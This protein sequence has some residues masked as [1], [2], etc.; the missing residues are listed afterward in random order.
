MILRAVAVLVLAAAL[1]FPDPGGAAVV[2]EGAPLWLRK[3]MERSA[4]T[5]WA[6]IRQDGSSSARDGLRLLSLV[7]ERVFAGYSVVDSF[8]RGEDAVLRLRPVERTASWRVEIFQPQLASPVGGWFREDVSGL[9]EKIRTHLGDLPVDALSWADTPLKELIDTLCSPR[10]PGWSA[11]LLVRLEQE[12]PILRVSFI[13]RPPFVLAVVPRVSS[14]TLPVMLRSDLNENIL[15]TLSPVVGLPIE[16][17][18]A[19]SEKVEEMAAES[20][21]QTNIVG[22]TRSVVDVS[23]KPAQIATADAFVDS[24]KYSVRAWVAAYAGSDTKYPEIGLHAG[25][26]FLPVS[27]W[28]MELYGE[29]ILTANDFTLESRWG[30]RWSP[31]KNVLAGVEQ[32]Y[33]GNV[34]WYRLWIEGGVRA[35]YLW[36]RVSEDGDHHAGAGYRLNRRISLEI[37]YDGRDDDKISI[38]A[39]SD[40]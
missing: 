14:D 7:A 4:A 32:A 40:L 2:I 11:S 37:H 13:P 34:T 35:P 20:L 21:R 19:H 10:L 6:E 17:V 12:G 31:W 23:F 38:R 1:L 30:I 18:S 28:D 16:W 24:P 9:G 5:V 26:K 29:W 39:L 27:G 33:P 15:R 22:N 25:R 8:Y 3:R 36:W